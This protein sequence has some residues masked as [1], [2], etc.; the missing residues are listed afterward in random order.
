MLALYRARVRDARA[1]GDACLLISFYALKFVA[2]LMMFSLSL[3]PVHCKCNSHKTLVSLTHTANMC[4]SIMSRCRHNFSLSLTH[5]I[6]ATIHKIRNSF[7]SNQTLFFSLVHADNVFLCGPV[8]DQKFSNSKQQIIKRVC[9]K[10]CRSPNCSL[11]FRREPLAIESPP[12]KSFPIAHRFNAPVNYRQETEG[13]RVS[14]CIEYR[15]MLAF[16][17]IHKYISH[18]QH[19]HAQSS[20]TSTPHP[21]RSHSF[22]HSV[23]LTHRTQK[24]TLDSTSNPKRFLLAKEAH[25]KAND[26]AQSGCIAP[27]T[28]IPAVTRDLYILS[29]AIPPPERR[30]PRLST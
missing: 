10:S 13:H 9:V 17:Y 1:R 18:R 27:K 26:I 29:F 14:V 3:V 4:A 23:T 8:D 16:I 5:A 19:T 7:N 15:Y 24:N 30:R 21:L 11:R 20:H 28:Q 12:I 6:A 22:S 2:S 25:T